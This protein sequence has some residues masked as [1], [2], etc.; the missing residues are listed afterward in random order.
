LSRALVFDVTSLEETSL[1]AMIGHKGSLSYSIHYL[2]SVSVI[3]NFPLLTLNSSSWLNNDSGSSTRVIFSRPHAPPRVTY[4][5]A[6]GPEPSVVALMKTGV[7]S[8]PTLM[9]K[10]RTELSRTIWA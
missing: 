4:R 2:Y 1:K 3:L 8:M 7:G 10:R 9:F 5:I 6:P